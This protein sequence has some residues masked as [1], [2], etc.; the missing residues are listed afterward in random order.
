MLALYS[1]LYPR[2]L[3]FQITII[4]LLV[5]CNETIKIKGANHEKKFTANS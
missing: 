2:T 3:T 4:I 5:S 1:I